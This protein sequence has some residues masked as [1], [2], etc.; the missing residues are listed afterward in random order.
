MLINTRTKKIISEYQFRKQ[1]N[2]VIFPKE[3]TDDILKQYNHANLKQTTCPEYDSW[4]Y[5]PVDSYEEVDGVW[6]QVWTLE[7]VEHTEEEVQQRL[8][9]EKERI[10]TKVDAMTSSK[11]SSGFFCDA[12]PPDTNEPESLFFSYDSFDQQNFADAAIVILNSLQTQ[13]ADTLKQSWNAYRNHTD[14]YKGDLIVLD[15][16][17]ATFLPIYQAACTHKA[18]VMTGGSILK[19]KIRNASSLEELEEID[20]ESYY[21]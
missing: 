15:L 21:V 20:L 3:L 11:I 18:T 12:T 8:E 10:I 4:N 17:P 1:Y 6:T 13:S 9:Q 14:D 2:N 5:K 7:P 16:T 19:E